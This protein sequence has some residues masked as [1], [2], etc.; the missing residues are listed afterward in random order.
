MALTPREQ[1]QARKE[2]CSRCLNGH[3]ELCTLKQKC[4]HYFCDDEE[5]QQRLVEVRATPERDLV[6]RESPIPPMPPGDL[7]VTVPLVPDPPSGV[8]IWEDPPLHFRRQMR[9]NPLQVQALKERPGEW[10]RVKTFKNRSGAT[11]AAS[12]CRKNGDAG[13]GEWEFLGCTIEPVDTGQYVHTG[14]LYAR[15]VGPGEEE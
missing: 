10:A 6:R 7:P 4:R 12:S 8:L 2:T 14:G 11:S 13:S 1:A 15:Y 5:F 3:H 9:I